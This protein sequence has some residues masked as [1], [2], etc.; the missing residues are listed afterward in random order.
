MP[1]FQPENLTSGPEG[2]ADIFEAVYSQRAIRK[3][4]N[5]P[6]S[7][8]ILRRVIEAATKAPSGTNRQPWRF[9]VV[10]DSEKRSRIAKMIRT[11]A[12]NN[13][14]I[15]EYFS[16]GSKSDDTGQR[17]MFTGALSLLNDLDQAPVYII[18]CLYRDDGTFSPTDNVLTGSSIYGAVQNLQ[19]VARALGLGTVLTTFQA[20]ILDE[21][22]PFLGI[23]ESALPCALIPLGYP[24][25][26]F[27][28]TR[29]L[30]VDDVL[31]WDSWED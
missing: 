26:N 19:L 20:P 21:L 23:P 29:R 7:D 25:A 14:G 12:E 5:E 3:F 2:T 27:G 4:K 9:L 15:R 28:P 18:P 16:E 10:R 22:R 30:P 11:N 8:E 1:D 13:P 17:L 24:D 6:V 31:F